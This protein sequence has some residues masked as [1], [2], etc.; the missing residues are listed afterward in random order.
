MSERPREKALSRKDAEHA[1]KGVMDKETKM[2]KTRK[3]RSF[4]AIFAA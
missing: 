3:L 2:F 1:K 4:L